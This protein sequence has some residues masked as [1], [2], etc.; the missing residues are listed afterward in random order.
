LGKE[1]FPKRGSV[2]RL[3]S[4]LGAFHRK[5]NNVSKRGK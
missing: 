2:G 1:G 3:T 5:M 4:L